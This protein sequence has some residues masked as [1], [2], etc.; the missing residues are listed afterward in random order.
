MIAFTKKIAIALILT[1]S[2]GHFAALAS[3]DEAA[4]GLTVNYNGA[5]VRTHPEIN[6]QPIQAFQ[7]GAYK[8]AAL[9]REALLIIAKHATIQR[10]FENKSIVN[11]ALVCRDWGS[12]FKV[13]T[14][15]WKLTH[16]IT[17]PEKAEIFRRFM[18]GV[19]IYKPNPGEG[20]YT[21][22]IS[23]PIRRLPNPL[24]SAFDISQCGNADRNLS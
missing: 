21:D 12:L 20:D 23:F 1:L 4:T 15:L 2:S 5:R 13:G 19:L 3:D 24:G 18:N 6:P 10:C 7:Q 9:P 8:N 16:G 14:P 17:T 22:G 11:L